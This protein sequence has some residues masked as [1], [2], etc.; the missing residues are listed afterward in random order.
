[1]YPTG[2]GSCISI[3][4]KKIFPW[5]FPV[6]FCLSVGASESRVQPAPKFLCGL[7]WAMCPVDQSASW[8][9]S[10]AQ[11][12]YSYPCGQRSNRT[13]EVLSYPVSGRHLCL[14]VCGAMILYSTN[15]TL[16]F[17]LIPCIQHKFSGTVPSPLPEGYS[18]PPSSIDSMANTQILCIYCC[19][20]SFNITVF[21]FLLV[22]SCTLLKM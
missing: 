7:L 17:N 8:S 5:T 3:G 14:Y 11:G 1:M 10:I 19:A 9:L 2:L 15:H 6:A 22:F 4:F 13:T 20:M 12:H 16:V 18:F 21:W